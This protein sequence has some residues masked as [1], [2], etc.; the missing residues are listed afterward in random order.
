M[1]AY[2]F[3]KST[4]E[5]VKSY[6]SNRF[7]RTKIN[8]S[9]SSWT[10]LLL[11]VPQCSV[12]GPLLFNVYLNDLFLFNKNTEVC[13]F[14]DDTTFHA[15]DNDILRVVQRLEQDSDIAIK[16]SGWNYMKL[17]EEKCHLMISG[18]HNECLWAQVGNSKI[19]ESYREK[20]L[21]IHIDQDLKFNYHINTVCEKQGKSYLH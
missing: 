5:L 21:G 3:D 13:N 16:W 4:L 1:E 2:G 9:F 17:N 12:L 20:L 14:A 8:T 7:Q 11:G 19:W 10:E 15:S 18:N 6:L